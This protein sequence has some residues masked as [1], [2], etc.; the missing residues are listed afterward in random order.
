M[1]SIRYSSR[2]IAVEFFAGAGGLSL[3]LEQAGFDVVLAVDRDGYHVATHERNFPYGRAVCESVTE[4]NAGKIRALL[5]SDR[6]IDLV[7]GGPP[8]Q[9]FSHMGTRDVFDPRNSL[10]EHFVRLVLELR[11][12][13]F[14]MENVP[15]M[16]SGSTA[17]IFRRA[18][19]QWEN[20]SPQYTIT[21]PVM[22]LNAADFGVPQNRER[23]FVLG[24]RQDLQRQATYPV[25][26]TDGQPNRPTVDEAIGDLP[27]VKNHAEMLQ[28]DWTD[29]DPIST[30]LS[31]YARVMRG[32]AV[33][34]SDY[35][36]PRI[37]DRSKCTCSSVVRHRPDIAS[38]YAA[39]RPGQMVPG[40]KLPK[41]LPDGL[42]PTLRA[43]SESEHGSYTAPR[44]VHPHEPRCI[45]A[46][47]AARLHGFPD[48]F[49]FYPRKWHAYRQIGNSVC[50]PVGRALGRQVLHALGIA[51]TQPEPLE[52]HDGFELPAVRPRQHRRIAQLS[53]WPKIL[54][55]LLKNAQDERGRLIRDEF[56]VTDVERAYAETGATMPRNPARRFL[57]DIAR[58]R[59]VDKLLAPIAKAGLTILEVGDNGTY[60]RFAP[61]GTPGALDDK[62]SLAIS[63]RDIPDALRLK[64]RST[65]SM[66]S[67]SGV[68][69]LRRRAV[70]E[71]LFGESARIVF[72]G[73]RN[74][75]RKFEVE[76][77][78]FRAMRRERCVAKG[79]V[80]VARG[81]NLPTFPQIAANLERAGAR[82]A[83]VVAAM[84]RQHLAVFLLFNRDGRVVLRHKKVFQVF[85]SSENESV[86]PAYASS[87]DSD[88]ISV[89]ASA[90]DSRRSE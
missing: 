24:V 72:R 21:K 11:P 5:D 18:I 73:S 7:A 29:Y 87:P 23:L 65:T 81:N 88:R 68:R 55:Q 70:A 4:L 80:V 15:G 22:T 6:E 27:K 71:A 42:A 45:T 31:E 1:N 49:R 76:N 67:D 17:E 10:V 62:H 50:P 48:W 77:L 86:S 38:L 25:R 90:S 19:E 66:T 34:P 8:C 57:A 14:L 16:Q 74:L 75:L 58:S 89:Q 79:I 35:S 52:L 2:P 9:G 83:L 82:A 84:T 39:T 12:K 36:Y 78:S 44:P 85:S 28:R 32:L 13:A 59:N 20:G 54:E 37:W 69:L 40:H 3:G 47:E 64:T 46:R 33:D 56:S 30:T 51:P 41:L 43:G 26:P 60:G 63:S 53:E 61:L